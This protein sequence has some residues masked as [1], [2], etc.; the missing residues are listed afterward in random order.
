MRKWLEKLVRRLGK[1]RQFALDPQLGG[2]EIL[3]IVCLTSAWF[4]RGDRKSVV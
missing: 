2:R 3:G 4:L 1:H